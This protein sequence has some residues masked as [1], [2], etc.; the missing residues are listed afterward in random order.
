MCLSA[1]T[2]PGSLHPLCQEPHRRSP[3]SELSA[4]EW[5]G[6]AGECSWSSAVP[7]GFPSRAC[8]CGHWCH[9][10]S[11]LPPSLRCL[12]LGFQGHGV[13]AYWSRR[14]YGSVSPWV[15]M[16]SRMCP[17]ICAPYDLSTVSVCVDGS[18]VPCHS[19]GAGIALSVS[20][21]V[22]GSVCQVCLSDQGRLRVCVVP[23]C[24]SSV[25]V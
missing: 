17:C 3:V 6:G 18:L 8:D 14:P 4:C 16:C 22:R 13:T 15:G 2:L 12:S 19:V 7:A 24:D 10:G 21:R 1:H 25:R 9:R 23:L 11:A 20:T 5:W